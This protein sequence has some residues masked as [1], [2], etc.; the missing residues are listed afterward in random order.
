MAKLPDPPKVASSKQ[1]VV[2]D[3]SV[4]STSVPPPPEPAFGAGIGTKEKEFLAQQEEAA[5]EEVRKELEIAPEVEKAGVEV[6]KEEIE[7]PPPLPKMGV[8]QTGA[9][10][11][12]S[13]PAISLPLTDDKIVGGLAASIWASLRWLAEWCLKQLKKAHVK[14]KKVHGQI[15]RVITK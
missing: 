15:V 11:P 10:L 8:A 5:L 14:L 2:S 1:Q 12:V 4:G 13:A 9:E 6:Q 3:D 7:L